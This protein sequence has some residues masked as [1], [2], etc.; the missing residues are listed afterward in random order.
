MDDKWY[1]DSCGQAIE[2]VDQGWVENLSNNSEGISKSY[3]LRIVHNE[4]KCRYNDD[5]K[6]REEGELVHCTPLEFYA[7]QDGFM[8][9]LTLI[10]DGGFE[11]NDEILEVI[12]RIFV[13]DYE[14]ARLHFKAAITEGYFDPNTK[15]GFHTESDIKSTMDYIKAEGIY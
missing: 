3:G 2:S 10:S 7:G 11:N 1:C 9:L 6:F 15:A 14:K 4:E 12:K 13:K 8:Q 5:A